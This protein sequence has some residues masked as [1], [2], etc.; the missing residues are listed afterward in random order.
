M[1]D[2]KNLLKQ[3]KYLYDPKAAST[4]PA[5]AKVQAKGTVKKK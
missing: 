4:A 1:S 5:K 2:F 3:K